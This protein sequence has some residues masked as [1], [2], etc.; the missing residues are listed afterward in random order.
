MQRRAEAMKDD[1]V[2]EIHDL[3]NEIK[4]IEKNFKKVIE[5]T[6]KNIF[7]VTILCL[8]FMINKNKDLFEETDCLNQKIEEQNRRIAVLDDQLK[9]ILSENQTQ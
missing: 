1:L 9:I 5:V 2:E 4:E 8:E 6:R 3:Y 7:S